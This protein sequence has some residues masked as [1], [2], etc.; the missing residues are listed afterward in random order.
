MPL[1]DLISLADTNKLML[2]IV[3]GFRASLFGTLFSNKWLTFSGE[4]N[5]IQVTD[6]HLSIGNALYIVR[7]LKCFGP[8]IRRL[9]ID[10]QWTRNS[11]LHNAIVQLIQ[12][13]CSET[14]IELRLKAMSRLRNTPFKKVDSLWMDG[15]ILN[16]L[17]LFDP[18]DNT[19]SLTDLFPNLRRLH[20]RKVETK[21]TNLI[22]AEY[23]H[24]EHL[25][26][27]IKDH[28]QKHL[29]DISNVAT[30]IKMNPTIR[31]LQLTKATRVLLKIAANSLPKLENLELC[32]YYDKDHALHIHFE[33]LKRLKMEGS[34]ITPSGLTFGAH[35]EEYELIYLNRPH[36][37]CIFDEFIAFVM[38]SNVKKLHLEWYKGIN[39]NEIKQMTTAQLNVTELYINCVQTIQKEMFAELIHSCENLQKVLFKIQFELADEENYFE[40][41]LPYLRNEF[42]R[43]W[44]ISSDDHSTLST[45]AKSVLLEKKDYPGYWMP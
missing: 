5:D 41:V 23:R 24:L 37:K 7:L 38:N 15:T 30:L 35:L 16:G 28:Y 27:K 12:G 42:R 45:M 18:Q 11:Q 32:D 33:H 2:S 25:S 10:A 19:F 14:L 9:E 26:V 40:G 6:E 22:L 29:L 43:Q 31:S 8:S 1:S 21:Y 34:Y 36:Y 20:M 3:R 44:E 4:H 39:S 17:C 13:Q